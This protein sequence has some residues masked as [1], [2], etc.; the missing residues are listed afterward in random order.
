VRAVRL[1]DSP[2]PA[3]W[4]TAGLTAPSITRRTRRPDR[5]WYEVIE[6]VWR[7]A[8]REVRVAAEQA[9]PEG[10]YSVGDTYV[11]GYFRGG[12]TADHQQD[13]GAATKI[14]ARSTRPPEPHA[15]GVPLGGRDVASRRGGTHS[16]RCKM[17][18]FCTVTM[19]RARQA[20]ASRR[21]HGCPKRAMCLR[22]G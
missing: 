20:C 5:G 17:V 1:A 7:K 2:D 6:A 18:S 16:D 13:L 10:V 11:F 8:L 14:G 21:G 9:Q 15:S 19:P 22:C 4:A 3:S 12:Q